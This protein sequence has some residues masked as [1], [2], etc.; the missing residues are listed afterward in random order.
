MTDPSGR[1]AALSRAA[2]IFDDGTL[3][4]RL[5][6]LVAIK[7]TAQ[8]PDY[9]AELG[10]Y[11]E[12]GIRPWLE[13]MGFDVAIH[14]NPV[15]GFGPIL[16]ATRVEDPARPTVLLYGHGNSMTLRAVQGRGY[17]SPHDARPTRSLE[18]SE[19]PYP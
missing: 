1:A 14:P 3:K 10:R 4:A 15:A 2:Q 9:D 12:Q 17:G 11:L 6:E 13:R 7:S 8:D 16:T 19:A 5:A 18:P